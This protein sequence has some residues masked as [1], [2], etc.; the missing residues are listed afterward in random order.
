M[1]WEI[2]WCGDAFAYLFISVWS[3][4]RYFYNWLFINN[5][6]FC[7]Y[8]HLPYPI[9]PVRPNLYWLM[10]LLHVS[11]S[12]SANVFITKIKLHFLWNMY[13]F[14]VICN[15]II[16]SASTKNMFFHFHKM[17]NIFQS[18]WRVFV[19]TAEFWYRTNIYRITYL[20]ILLSAMVSN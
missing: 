17:E 8:Q 20:N 14:F 2:W 10:S 18:N 11:S 1:Y 5:L 19:N 9:A 6:F 13:K 4:F 12:T 7:I 3:D 15:K 16:F